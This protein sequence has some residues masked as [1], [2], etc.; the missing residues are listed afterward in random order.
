MNPRFEFNEV[1]SLEEMVVNDVA[2]VGTP[3]TFSYYALGNKPKQDKYPYYIAGINVEVS[4]DETKMYAYSLD[5]IA[6]LQIIK[7]LSGFYSI[8]NTVN[9]SYLYNYISDTHYDIGYK[10]PSGEYGSSEW[11]I[12]KE[13]EGFT[14]YGVNDPYLDI[15]SQTT[16]LGVKEKP[17]MPLRVYSFS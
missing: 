3:N 7:N 5:E 14:F 9:K 16:F 13:K 4:F 8:Y 15:S 6:K 17:S 1:T 11:I 2:I 12:T 10:V